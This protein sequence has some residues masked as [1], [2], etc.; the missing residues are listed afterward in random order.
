MEP[1]QI[2]MARSIAEAGGHGHATFHVGVVT[3]HPFEDD[4]SDLVHGHAIVTSVPDTRAVLAEVKRVLKPGGLV[5]AR[6][7]NFGSSVLA[8]DYEVIGESW[9]GLSEH[10]TAADGHPSIGKELKRH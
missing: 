7:A 8:P 9:A 3:D 4:Y 2:D 10:I 6:E 5:S 1:S